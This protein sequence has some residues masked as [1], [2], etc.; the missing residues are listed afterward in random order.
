MNFWCE[1]AWLPG[2]LA[3]RVLIRVENGVIASVSTV[4]TIPLG[5]RR[6]YG[7]VVPGF[8]NAHSHAFHRAL[9]GRTHDGGGTFWTWREGMY[10]LA[11]KLFSRDDYIETGARLA[12]GCVWAYRAFPTGIMPEKANM[13]ICRTYDGPCAAML[14]KDRN[15]ALP[16]GFMRMIDSRYILRPEAIESV[17][18][19]WRITGDQEWRDAAWTMWEAIVR[20][21]E[22]ETAFAAIKDVREP[23][24]PKLDEMEVSAPE[25]AHFGQNVLLTGDRRFGWV[26]RS[27]IST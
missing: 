26:R 2:G 25:Q 27:S 21:T 20:E 17:F 23:G 15:H 1:R 10:A 22:T 3:E 5:V 9:R 4:D 13:A 6:L 24:G 11:G 12:R 18:Y 7:V 16:V 19:L 8:A 14:P